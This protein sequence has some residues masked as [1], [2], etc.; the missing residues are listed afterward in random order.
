MLL[1]AMWILTFIVAIQVEANNELFQ[2]SCE[3]NL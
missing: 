1:H 2:D 3:F